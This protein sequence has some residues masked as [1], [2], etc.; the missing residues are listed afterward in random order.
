MKKKLLVAALTLVMVFAFTACGGGGGASGE[1]EAKSEAKPI[2]QET[3]DELAE[4]DW[5]SMSLEDFN[6]YFGKEGVVDEERTKDWGEG[7]KVVDWFNEDESGYIHVLFKEDD[8]GVFMPSSIS[9]S[10]P[11]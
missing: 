4:G 1:G 5:S 9:P 8:E 3:Y 2:T 11:E 10:F 6:E 7:Y